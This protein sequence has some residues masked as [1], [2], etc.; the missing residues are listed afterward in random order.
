MAEIRIEDN[1]NNL[2]ICTLEKAAEALNCKL[3]YVLIPNE[4]LQ[5][6]VKHQAQKK[7]ASMLYD[8]NQHMSL[9]EQ[10]I[11]VDEKVERAAQDLL[12]RSRSKIWDVD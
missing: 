2:K 6:V 7:A 1:E 5:E 4:P 9:E 3:F 11:D 10:G 12:F 8:L